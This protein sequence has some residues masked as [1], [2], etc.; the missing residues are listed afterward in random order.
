MGG[1]NEQVVKAIQGLEEMHQQR[2]MEAIAMVND[3]RGYVPDTLCDA[4]SARS[5]PSWTP[6]GQAS[7]TTQLRRPS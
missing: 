5:C 4:L 1:A 7:G 3:S 6:T 2:L